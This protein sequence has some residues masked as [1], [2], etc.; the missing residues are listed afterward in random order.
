MP[1]C[2]K[3]HIN[4]LCRKTLA[5][6]VSTQ[7]DHHCIVDICENISVQ[8]K[9]K[10]QWKGQLHAEF[11]ISMHQVLTTC[12]LSVSCS[13]AGRERQGEKNL[14]RIYMRKSVASKNM[15]FDFPTG[16]WEI[17]VSICFSHME[18]LASNC[19]LCLK[20]DTILNIFC[21]VHCTLEHVQE[22]CGL[23]FVVVKPFTRC[24][25]E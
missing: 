14:R 25:A 9:I 7:C 13:L 18:K 8:Y 21:Q 23:G 2:G 24:C 16:N 12:V 22:R 5:P 17:F 10:Y 1:Q 3:C 15:I 11:S 19:K 20:R 4:C 6:N